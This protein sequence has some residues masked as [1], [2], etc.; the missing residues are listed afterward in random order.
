MLKCKR[1]HCHF[2]RLVHLLT[3]VLAATFLLSNPSF[4]KS[5]ADVI[6]SNS[7]ISATGKPSITFMQLRIVD[8]SGQVI[9]DLRTDGSPV[10]WTLPKGASDGFYSYEVSLGKEPKKEKRDKNNNHGIGS[11]IRAMIESGSVLV[12]NGFIVLPIEE[13]TSMLD[14]VLFIGSYAFNGIMDFIVAPAAADQVILDDLI[15]DGSICAGLDCTNGESFG[16]DTIRLK[17]NNLRIRFVD[18]SSTSSFPSRDWQITVNDSANGGLN[19]FSIDD[20]DG[21]RTPFTIEG[22]APSHSLYV[23]DSGRVG[24]GTSTPVVDMH[25]KTGNTPTVRLEQDG[26]SGFTPQTWDVA[27]NEANFFVRDATNG[28]TLPLRIQPGGPSS[29][30]NLMADGGVVIGKW[31]SGLDTTLY[32]KEQ[33]FAKT[34]LLKMENYASEIVFQVDNE[35]NFGMVAEDPPIADLH[36]VGTSTALTDPLPDPVPVVL[37]IDSK[38]IGSTVLTELFRIEKTGDAYLKGNLE[39]GSSRSLK[40]NIHALNSQDAIDALEILEPVHFNYRSSPNVHSIGFIAEDVPDLVATKERKSLR[41]MDIIA[42]LTKVTQEQQK[43]IEELNTTIAQLQKKIGSGS[44]SQ[45]AV[46]LQ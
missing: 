35:G 25:I 42:V 16:F 10:T 5:N 33:N 6:I 27:G 13:E 29:V 23:D 4:A 21:G 45:P 7:G 18:T 38:D 1:N 15:V 9:F 34:S 37:R 24:L 2:N 8:P 19:K 46:T 40:Q 12:K 22:N 43:A 11:K 30:L 39:L 3:I 26:S 44:S 36:F 41:P 17:E 14:T 28:S 32:V 31:D 20:I